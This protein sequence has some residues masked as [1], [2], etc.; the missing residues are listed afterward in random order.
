[1][2]RW[3]LVAVGVVVAAI[4]VFVVWRLWA[5]V[6]GGSRAYAA[7]RARIRPVVARLEAGEEPPAEDLERF[8]ADRST[9]KVLHEELEAH[10]KLDLFPARFLTQEAMAEADLCAW[11]NHPN[12]LA[13]VPDDIELMEILPAPGDADAGR[14]YLFRYRMHSPHWA[15]ND[16]WMAGVAGP[17]PADGPVARFA[18]GTF[19][20]FER[21]DTR[22]PDEH[23][24]VT[25]DLVVERKESPSP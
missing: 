17:Y 7:L 23:V 18:P 20:R 2:L 4:V 16:G 9:R 19:S 3:F 25:H 6:V 8:A 12:E 1:M 22:T 15:A 21:W 10:G 24:R 14:Y 5:T 11:L 13:A